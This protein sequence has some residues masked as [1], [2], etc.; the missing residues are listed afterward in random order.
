MKSKYIVAVLLAV[1]AAALIYVYMNP[2]ENGPVGENNSQQNSPLQDPRERVSQQ[3]AGIFPQRIGYEW[4][5]SGFAEY[6]HRMKLD[7]ISGNTDNPE[8]LVYEVS[9]EVDDPSGGEAPGDFGLELEYRITSDT[10]LE[11]IIRGE[12]LAH[13]FKELQLLKLPLESGS[14]WEQTV[15]SSGKEVVL[16]AEILSAEK[17]EDGPDVYKV[18]YSVPMEGMPDGIY[19][20][21][22][23]FTEGVG[24]TSFARTLGEDYD[25][26]FEYSI[27]EPDK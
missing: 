10:V 15:E 6:G 4:F 5:Y 20:E 14:R 24:V 21:E 26:M 25:F 27:F 1:L 17:K 3:L 9:G 13:M 22:R 2:G 18:R 7:N 16:T 23:T 8:I 12:K 11:R 19:I